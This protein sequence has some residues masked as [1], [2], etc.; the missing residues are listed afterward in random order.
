[1]A[2][3]CVHTC[4][5]HWEVQQNAIESTTKAIEQKGEQKGEQT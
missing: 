5:V 4:R 1:M 2:V 3:V